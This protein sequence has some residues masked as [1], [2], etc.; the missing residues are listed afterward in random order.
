[1]CTETKFYQT[2]YN[3]IDIDS[4]VIPSKFKQSK[5]SVKKLNQ[6]RLYFNRFKCLDKPI[7]LFGNKLVD[8]Y[9]RYLVAKE[10]GL[11]QIPCILNKGQWYIKGVFDGCLKEYVW[12]VPE[13]LEGIV[14][15]GDRVVVYNRPTCNNRAVVT[16][17]DILW[18][19][20]ESM[21][22]HSCVLDIVS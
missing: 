1:M 6:A 7:S 17:R 15:F 9:I 22:N 8:G 13:H 16:V 14:W 2:E 10:N 12:R 18:S 11:K 3:L 4:I 5:P 20:D 19:E 21:L